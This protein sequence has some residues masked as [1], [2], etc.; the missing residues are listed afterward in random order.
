M[1]H[2]TML[3]MAFCMQNKLAEQIQENKNRRSAVKQSIKDFNS[4]DLAFLT[5]SS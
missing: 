1:L 3:H 4:F 2:P 5:V